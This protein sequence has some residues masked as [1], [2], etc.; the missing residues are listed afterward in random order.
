M[1]TIELKNRV[2]S[3]INQINDEAV[4]TEIYKLLD[5]SFIDPDT[6]HLSDDHMIA[7]DIAIEQIK[8]GEYLTQEQSNIEMKEWLNK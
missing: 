2:I 5:D 1:T 4:L 7:I 3:R 8:N 6:Y